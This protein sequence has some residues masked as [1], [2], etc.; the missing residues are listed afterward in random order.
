MFGSQTVLK[1]WAPL[2]DDATQAI[3]NGNVIA[4][5]S[6]TLVAGVRHLRQ[7]TQNKLSLRMK[8]K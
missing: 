2:I 6:I 4:K 3:S 8:I 5:Y 1:V 7:F